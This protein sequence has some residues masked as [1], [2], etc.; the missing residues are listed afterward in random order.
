MKAAAVT[1]TVTAAAAVTAAK[2]LAAEV[3]AVSVV[4]VAV[5]VHL[6][7]IQRS[8]VFSQSAYVHI[9]R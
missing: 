5:S 8:D 2:V 9:T 6:R 3:A 7:C 4:T 1:V